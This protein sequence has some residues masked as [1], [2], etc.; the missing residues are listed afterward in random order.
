MI[1]NRETWSSETGKTERRTTRTGVLW[2][3]TC[4][5]PSLLRRVRR[6]RSI[7][8]TSTESAYDA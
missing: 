3:G 6:R 2:Y 8:L 5:P 1:W 4:G 7:S